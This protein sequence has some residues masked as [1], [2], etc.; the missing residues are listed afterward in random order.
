MSKSN[1]KNLIIG[2]LLAI[3]LIMAVGYAAFATNLNI[4]GSSAITSNWDV[5][6]KDGGVN[7]K[8][9]TQGAAST[10]ARKVDALTG[11]FACTLQVPGTSSIEYDIEVENL[12]SFDAVL[13]TVTISGT[14]EAVSAV[15]TEGSSLKQGDTIEK[16]GGTDT[17]TIKVSLNDI[18][19]LPSVTTIDITV[20]LDFSQATGSGGST[21]TPTG[22]DTPY[23]SNTKSGTVYAWNT[24]EITIGTST[25]NDLVSTKTS[26]KYYTSAADV[27][28]ASGYSHFNKYTVVNDIIT[29]GYTCQT[30]GISGFTPVCLKMSI[31]GSEYGYDTNGNHTGN[32]GI[33]KDLDDNNTS[34]TGSCGFNANTSGCSVGDLDLS[35]YAAGDVSADNA[36][37]G[38]HCGVSYRFGAR[39]Y[40]K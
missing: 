25:I 15:V 28:S 2:G 23:D 39:C 1:K 32:A 31:D 40:E 20:K 12:G 21:P 19:Q 22:G 11:E 33:L 38:A 7:A 27:M 5:H 6:I 13:D 37:F 14:T 30:F 16:N 35:A 8:N 17:L 3:V 10:K 18:S 29:E 36:A 4:N 9:P 26:N 24:T 34:F